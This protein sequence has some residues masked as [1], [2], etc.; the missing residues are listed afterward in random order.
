MKFK[1]VFIV[2]AV[3]TLVV[4]CAKPPIAEMDSAR[5]A[6]FRAEN[7][8]DAVIYGSSSLARAQAALKRMQSEADSKRYDAARTNAEEA[9]T[10]AEKAIAD[11]KAG[12]V[13]ARSESSSLLTGLIQ[14]IDEASRNVSGARYSQLNLDYNALEKALTGAYSAADRAE[15]ANAEGRHQDA[16]NIAM[17][18]R[19]ELF[20]INQ[21]ISNAVTR[22]K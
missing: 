16:L 5:E 8:A 2:C 13:R 7:D 18:I 14:E 17:E 11:G 1:Y 19:S 12:A 10:A 20:R 4:A 22:K 9:V 6:V 15:A 3:F 21:L